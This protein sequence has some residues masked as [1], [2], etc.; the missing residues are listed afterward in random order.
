[1]KPPS[2]EA[3]ALGALK[4]ENRQLRRALAELSILNELAVE[5]GRLGTSQEI[6]ETIVRRAVK[7]VEAEQGSI[8]LVGTEGAAPL[9]TL[10]RAQ[11]SSRPL[12]TY[13]FAPSLLGWIELNRR[14]LA[15]GDPAADPRFRGVRFDASIRSIL[16]VPLLIKSE[17][18]AVLAVYNKSS[19]GTFT[20]DDQR[21]LSIIAAQSAQ[22]LENARLAEQERELKEVQDELRLAARIQAR[23]LPGEAPRL[24]GY[25]LAGRSIAA[26]E[27]GGD[28]FDFIPAGGERLAICLGDVAGK[29]MP[30]SLLM[31]NLQAMVR[32]QTGA[33]T[34]PHECVAGSNRL[35]CRNTGPAK[36][37]TFFYSILDPHRHLLSY[38]NAGHNPPLYCPAEGA[39]ERLSTGGLVL[40]VREAGPYREET[41]AL[42]PGDTVV[43]YSDGITEAVD[44][45]GEELGE[46]RLSEVIAAARA[47]SADELIA[48]I[49]HAVAAHRQAALQADDMTLVVLRR[50]SG[51]G[52]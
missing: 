20:P 28:Y 38:C 7:A 30:A 47:G 44:P 45:A 37:I 10:I 39:I 35:I 17:L 19:G 5:T 11:A 36:F 41:L 4:E 50:T 16:A 14:P 25:D 42:D 8:T 6:I 40:G 48:A 46:E 9:Q 49:I 26:R 13:H 51:E 24:P 22:V 23:L 1:V 31:A 27:V 15:V 2:P 32:A 3:P 29:G 34:P 52:R 43:I 33:S 21:L 18:R 12:D